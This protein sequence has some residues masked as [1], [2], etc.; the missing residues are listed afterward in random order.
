MP[1]AGDIKL[2]RELGKSYQADRKFIWRE[3]IDCGEGRWVRLVRGAP[4]RARC[5]RCCSKQ[6][7][8]C[9]TETD[10]AYAAGLIDGD[11]SVI[12]GKF[13]A[14]SQ[15]QSGYRLTVSVGMCDMIAPAWF[16]TNF[17]G[18]FNNYDRPNVKY[19]R[20]YIWNI[21]D[22]KA[23]E[24]LRLLLPYLKTK[25]VQAEVAIEYQEL[26]MA[27]KAAYTYRKPEAFLKAEAAFAERM[28]QLNQGK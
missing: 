22:S 15:R 3:C 26:K 1:N 12:I 17:G 4:E 2:G 18:R 16:H 7:V 27:K 5:Y 25:R 14:R 20:V 9:A 8:T 21:T 10:L 13:K 11:G 23:A 24:L 6:H 28:H 19:R